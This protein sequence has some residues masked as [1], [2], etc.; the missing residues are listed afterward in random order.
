M[1]RRVPPRWL[2]GVLSLAAR[3]TTAGETLVGDLAEGYRA[4][5]AR[6]G[7]ARADVW[8]LRQTVSMLV[9]RARAGVRNWGGGAYGG[10][11]PFRRDAALTARGM[12]RR[13]WFGLG[14]VLILTLAVA[15]TTAA[16]SLAAGTY[17]AAIW[18][19]DGARTVSLWPEVRLGLGHLL[20]LRQESPALGEIGAWTTG[21]SAL[22]DDEDG[23]R[24]VSAARISPNVFAALS[25]QPVLGRGLLPEDEAIGAEPVVVIGWDLWQS[26]LG[27]DPSV[28][29][30][31]VPVDGV[32][33]RIVGVQGRGG[34]APGIG[35]QIWTPIVM[36]AFDPDFWP[37][38]EYHLVARVPAGVSVDE[39]R[40]ELVRVMQ[41]LAKRF[42][43]F[44]QAD[45][46]LDATAAPANEP[47]WRPL[48]TPLALLLAG[49]L[50]LLVVAA[51]DLGN[52]FLGR[53]LERADELRVRSVLGASRARIVGQLLVEGLLWTLVGLAV[54][55]GAGLALAGRLAAV[56]P[57]GSQ[58]VSL[59]MGRGLAAY[60]L[61]TGALVWGLMSGVPIAHFLRTTRRV[62][63]PNRFAG[64]RAQG[65]LVVTQ[66]ALATT[67][68]VGAGLLMKSVDN[69][70]RIPVGFDGRD[71]VA[72]RVSPTPAGRGEDLPA[73]Y[74]ALG[75]ALREGRGV[76]AVG[77]AGTLPLKDPV[78]ISPINRLDAPTEVAAAPRA[79]RHV[80]DEGYFDA[81]RIRVLQG[82]GIERTDDAGSEQVVVVNATMA[83]QLWPGEDPIGRRIAVDPHAFEAWHTVVGVVDDVRFQDLT[84]APPP[85]YYVPFAQNPVRE[86]YAVVAGSGDAR[87]TGSSVKVAVAALDAS[88]ALSAPLDVG[89]L[90]TDAYGAVRIMMAL[91]GVLALLATLLGAVGLYGSLAS[92]VTRHRVEL[93]T[94][95][96]LGARPERIFRSVVGVGAALTAAGIVLG[97]GLAVL[98]GGLVRGLLVGVSPLD[99]ASF[100]VTAV[101]LALVGIVAAAVP[102]LR[103][104]TVPPAQVLREG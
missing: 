70:A 1:I 104:A 47:V 39:A 96:A 51:I 38:Q 11:E 67:L 28:L 55:V 37:K 24:S 60:A 98:A 95:L 64:H 27:G 74:R 19:A 90:V 31:I 9:H 4:R 25:V 83:R 49:S 53:S 14:V 3:G 89:R 18:W 23:A 65:A 32:R 16:V 50:L 41:V 88:A 33:R 85:A 58:V 73:F 36:D 44:Y 92:Y 62:L 102:A 8:Y 66:A 15:A 45:F 84:F 72:L 42:S 17:R 99:P 87:G 22:E 69:L 80:V 76:R 52:L 57:V 68:L 77:L 94:R 2:E 100:G 82:R 20:T 54:G 46:G 81:F 29:D 56:F 48:R 101:A 34:T 59:G 26:A 13:P 10:F 40:A 12:A 21:T 93:S 35:T 75:D 43:F 97:S 63:V 78:A 71:A 61:G 79:F 103:A 30:R 7:P 91:L 5:A 6:H 86:M